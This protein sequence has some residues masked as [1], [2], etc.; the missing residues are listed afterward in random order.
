M[1]KSDSKC[2]QD[3]EVHDFK[4]RTLKFKKV[5]P[6]CQKK[7]YSSF[8]TESQ[9]SAAPGLSILDRKE[10]GTYLSNGNYFLHV[11]FY[12]RLT[13]RYQLSLKQICGSPL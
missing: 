8:S 11:K 3:W 13:V 1:H 7:E 9:W 6:S 5:F 4:S 12:N 2:G 10:I